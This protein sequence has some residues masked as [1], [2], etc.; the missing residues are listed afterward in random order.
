MENKEMFIF[1]LNTDIQFFKECAYFT[2][3]VPSTK[4]VK[5]GRKNRCV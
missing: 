1:L 2:F 5:K 4:T 3:M